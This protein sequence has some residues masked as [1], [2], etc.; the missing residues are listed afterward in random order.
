MAKYLAIFESPKKAAKVKSFLGKDYE[1]I[2]SFGH[3]IDLPPKKFSIDI[4]KDFKPTYAIMDDKK[5]VVKDIVARAKKAQIVYLMS[6]PDREGE[7]IS[8]HISN[9]FPKGTVFKRATYHSVTKKAFQ[10]AIKN[11]GNID[12]D[13]VNAYE[14][15]R[16]L[17]RLVGYRCS[18]ITQQAT[19]GR[20]AG[21][22]QSAALRIIADR[23]KEIQAFVPVIYWPI[24]AE[25]L[26][27]GK[28]KEKIMADIKK[29]KPLDISTKAEADKII[30]VLRNGPIK[31]SKYEQKNVSQN[32]YAPFQTSTLYQCAASVGIN[33]SR[34]KSA[35]QSLYNQGLITYMRT[36]SVYIVPEEVTKIRD[37]IKTNY[38]AK[39]H[40]ATAN[41]YKN[42]T[43]NA[44]EAH[45]AIRPTNIKLASY[46]SGT[47][48]EKKIY[49]MIWRRT[50]ASQ[51]ASAKMLRSSAEFSCNKYLLGDSG[52]KELFDG[53]RKIWTYSSAQ[54]KY[55]P[56]LTVG[57]EVDAIDITTERKET[58]PPKRYS[59]SSLIEVLKKEGIGRPSTYESI[60]RTIENRKYVE[61][62]KKAYHAT[63]LG[64]KVS[65]FLVKSD[66]CFIDLKFTAGVEDK[67]DEIS[68]KKN[69]K[70]TVLSDFWRRLKK[71]LENAKM[72]KD[73]LSKSK[74]EC[75]LC[76]K[77]GKK[78]FLM[79]K[80]SKYGA[81]FSCENYSK[82]D[83]GCK[84]TAQVNDDGTPKEKVKKPPPKKSKFNCPKCGKVMF[85]RNGPYGEFLGCSKF[86]SCRG[87]RDISGNVKKKKNKYKKYK[88]K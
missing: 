67:L 83:T 38:D 2:A 58:Q 68:N 31:V 29:P 21:R 64:L 53:F 88:N 36:D 44:Q 19:G 57:E 3:V 52:S 32:P 43:A 55:L 56:I 12:I 71:D 25:L 8:W 86:P 34:T 30:A 24:M 65:E 39:Y 42:K 41:F 45:E 10:D 51:M 37:Y 61:K 82:E 80:H 85:V 54:E 46:M 79:Q 62:Q 47:S 7:A 50:I 70:L 27:R 63:A 23:E 17:D 18:Y 20:S 73:N 75:P 84:Y 1:G 22:C 66:F 78:A 33:M 13:M 28:P 49:E 4:K 9:Q 60:V 11:A 5:D 6:D 87:L 48:D 81:F 14:A 74:Y 26:T 59:E 69:D 76:K 77:A 16:I 15:R 35:A 72:V 40:T